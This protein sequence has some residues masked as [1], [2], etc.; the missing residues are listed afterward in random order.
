MCSD[1]LGLLTTMFTHFTLT[2][3][4]DMFGVMSTILLF[5]FCLFPQFFVPLFSFFFLLLGYL[6]IFII[7]FYLSCFKNICFSFVC[8][9]VAQRINIYLCFHFLLRIHILPLQVCVDTLPQ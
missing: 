2:I 4:I 6:N 3:I 7:P 1:N 9:V 8:L 5:D